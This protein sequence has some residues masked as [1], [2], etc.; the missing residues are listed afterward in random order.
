MYPRQDKYKDLMS[1]SS[2]EHIKL[3][4]LYRF[5]HRYT[6]DIQIHIFRTIQYWYFRSIV[7]HIQKQLNNKPIRSSKILGIDTQL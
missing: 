3:D 7:N 2:L 1:L 5:Q 4:R 6:F